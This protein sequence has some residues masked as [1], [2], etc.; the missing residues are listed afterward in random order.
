MALLRPAQRARTVGVGTRVHVRQHTEW[1][2]ELIHGECEGDEPIFRHCIRAVGKAAK[3]PNNEIW[4]CASHVDI[5]CQGCA[6]ICAYRAP[7]TCTSRSGQSS[8]TM[9]CRRSTISGISA[10]DT[11][12]YHE[13]A[14][15]FNAKHQARANR[16]WRDQSNNEVIGHDGRGTRAT[17]ACGAAAREERDTHQSGLLQKL[18]CARWHHRSAHEHVCV[19]PASRR[20]RCE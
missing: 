13:H 16:C 2:L 17:S 12:A 7:C 18:G 9:R 15:L 19:Q 20:Q 4:S 8:S 1:A 11:T 5:Y 10:W 3:Y 6:C 14:F